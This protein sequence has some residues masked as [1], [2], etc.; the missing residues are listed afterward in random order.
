MCD[1]LVDRFGSPPEEVEKL[2][3]IIRIKIRAKE[4]KVEQ[5]IQQKQNIALRFAV[6]PGITGEQLME[7]ASKFPYPLSFSAAEQGKLEFKVR[8]R[9][10][11]IDDIFK[12]ILKLLAILKEYINQG[13]NKKEAINV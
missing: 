7:I 5:M 4:L 2:L 9:L 6:D 13:T 11:S 12:T 8:L 1:E 3:L 10:L